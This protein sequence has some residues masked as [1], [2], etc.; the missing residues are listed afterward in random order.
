MGLWGREQHR[1]LT[2]DDLTIK[3]DDNQREYLDV[4]IAKFQERKDGTDPQKKL[5]R[6]NC[7]CRATKECLIEWLKIFFSKRPENCCVPG[8]PLYLTPLRLA[9]FHSSSEIW[10]DALPMGINKIG[11]LLLDACTMAGIEKIPNRGMKKVSVKK[12]VEG[13]VVKKED[14]TEYEGGHIVNASDKDLSNNEMCSNSSDE[15]SNYFD[16]EGN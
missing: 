8:Y 9:R 6:Y 16:S 11:S 3:M 2:W 5:L 10:Y 13:A 14:L 15:V 7:V 12:E 4:V 1:K